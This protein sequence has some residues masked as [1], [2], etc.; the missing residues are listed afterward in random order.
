MNAENSEPAT[1]TQKISH[2]L[3][4][5]LWIFVYLAFFFCVFATYRM[6]ILNQLHVAYFAFG[7]ALINALV[8]SKVIL[9][10]EVLGVGKPQERRSIVFSSLY[11]AFVF[12]ILVALAH[13]LEEG[14]RGAVHGHTLPQLVDDVRGDGWLAQAIRALLIFAIFIPFFGFMEIRRTLGKKQ[15]KDLILQRPTPPTS[16]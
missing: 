4:E 10:G 15:F 12:A 6:M 7:T 11:K 13:F 1:L 14:I 5:W 2:E 8:L 9:I 3:I 16:R